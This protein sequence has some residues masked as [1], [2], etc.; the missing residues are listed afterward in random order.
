MKK[1]QWGLL[2][3][4]HINRAVIPPIRNSLRSELVAVASRKQSTGEAYAKEWNIPR[5]HGSYEALLDDPDI[6]A[7]YV[8]VPNHLHAEWSIKCAA[9]G[10]HVLCEK[11]LALSAIDVDRIIAAAKEHRVVIAEAFMYRHHPQTLKVLELLEKRVVGD[12]LLVKGTFTFSLTRP[13]DTRWSPE[14]G[15]GSIWDVGCYPIGFTRLIAGAEPAE[16]FGWQV[17]GPTGIDEVFVGQ[18]RFENGLLAQFES[19]F[20]SPFR[21]SMEIIGTTGT[22]MLKKPFK[23][24][25]D[26]WIDIKHE[27][28][29]ESIDAP[30][31]ELYKGEIEDMENAVLDRKPQRVSLE[32]SRGNVA[33]IK[34]L[35]ESARNGVPVRLT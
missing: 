15:G 34:A 18:M 30:S 5:V 20:R 17:R 16:V 14:M 1:L 11:P 9:A 13:G 6:N 28:R 35:L 7:V 21:T 31:Q 32:D 2:S 29:I 3:T 12:I 23:P 19:G 10:K 33:L 24:V 27:D 4:A 8:S 25:S 26:N 22:I